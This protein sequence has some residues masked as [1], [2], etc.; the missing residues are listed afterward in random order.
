MLLVSERHDL[1]WGALLW[2]IENKTFVLEIHESRRGLRGRKKSGNLCG[3]YGPG[4]SVNQLA[5]SFK[6]INSI[7]LN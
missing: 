2:N 4:H 1:V 7:D 5:W 3:W 6:T